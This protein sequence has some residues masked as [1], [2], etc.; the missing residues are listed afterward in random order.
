ML[1]KLFNI[2]KQNE[3]YQIKWKFQI[4]IF[5]QIFGGTTN[6]TNT[7]SISKMCAQKDGESGES[8]DQM[9]LYAV[10]T[11]IRIDNRVSFGAINL[12]LSILIVLET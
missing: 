4:Q 2:G 10:K 3:N 6:Y 5:S 8:H 11:S 9:K 7:T 12:F 1:I